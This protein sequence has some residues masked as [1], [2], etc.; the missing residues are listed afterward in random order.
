MRM[1]R[2]EYRRAAS[3]DEAV[4]LWAEQPG[5]RYLAGGTDLLP[6]LRAGHRTLSRAV[7]IK[8][9]PELAQIVPGDD[10]SL[11]VGAAASLT[12]IAAHPAIQRRYPIVAECCLAVGAH[13]LR[14]RATM[15][16]NICN[17]S[18]A[19]DTAVALLAVEAAVELLGPAGRRSVPVSDWFTGPGATA[20]EPGELVTR[21]VL[22]A[23]PAGWRGRYYR[24]SRRKGMDLATVGVLVARAAGAGEP[25][26]RVVLAAVAP[27]PLRVRGA[28]QILDRDGCGDPA[29]C[30]AAELACEQCNPITDVRG[31]AE[32]R[33]EMVL[34]LVARGARAVVEA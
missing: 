24:L 26:H 21:I 10:G 18:P 16:G 33:R 2:F 20:M 12:D 31:T 5:A 32:Y 23:R 28:E 15:A 9:V 4:T 3:A 1:P 19:A 29:A 6:Q 30:R 22:P 17:A 14:N 11:S 13:A 8:R 25:E 27:T 7:D 34:T